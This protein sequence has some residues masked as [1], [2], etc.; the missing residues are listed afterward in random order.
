MP[1][2]TTRNLQDVLRDVER[3][4]QRCSTKL[5]QLQRHADSI[6]QMLAYFSELEGTVLDTSSE[7]DES[8]RVS[9][10]RSA[11]ND[12][13]AARN[14][15]YEILEERGEPMHARDLLVAL[16]RRGLII[17]GKDPVNNVRAHLSHDVRFRPVGQGKWDL[18]NRTRVS[19][20]LAA[21]GSVTRNI[22]NHPFNAGN[23]D[24]VVNGS[25]NSVPTLTDWQTITEQND[26]SDAASDDDLEPVPF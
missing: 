21:A 12:A 25:R 13:K 1:R 6:R 11:P 26:W 14:A 2:S 4:V 5:D 20:G 10:S 16:E 15:L 22:A 19:S 18:V 8:D 7:V 24:I 9:I 3:E 17:R 23:T